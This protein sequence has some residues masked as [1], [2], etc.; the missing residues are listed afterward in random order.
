[1]KFR[2]LTVIIVLITAIFTVKIF[3]NFQK[4]WNRAE[5]FQDVIINAPLFMKHLL[6]P[7]KQ[8]GIDKWDLGD[9]A[10][11]QLKT[12]TDSRR[13]SFSV[14]AQESGG[15]KRHWLRTDGLSQFNA[16]P[17]EL[18]RLLSEAS[19]LPGTE[20]DGFFYVG[21]S[22][23]FPLYPAMFPP[24]PILLQDLGAETVQ[25]PI[26]KFKCRHYFVQ[27]RAPSGHL[28]PLLELWANTSVPPLGI[29]RARWRDETLDL[30]D[31]KAPL[32]IE[33]PDVLSE[34]FNQN[35]AQDHGCAQC[36]HEDIGGKDLKFL[37]KYL[38]SSTE[39]N[40]TQYLFHYYQTGL[41]LTSDPIRLQTISKPGQ[42]TSRELVQFTW[43][44]GSFWVKA[45]QRGQLTFSLDH[46]VSQ[47]KL[48][49]IPRKGALVLNLQKR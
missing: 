18:W 38:L 17:L 23:L 16:A 22:F 6:I 37:S 46:L 10:A 29:V 48:S 41:I 9:Y 28:E 8:L 40:L 42:I 45:N 32:P 3:I 47:G 39:L 19:L 5:I 44:K 25:T 26:G 36:H 30:V 34:T 1:M 20:A 7:P 21:K 11:Y 4:R 49:V 14:D 12:N 27:A 33:I 2:L 24:S 43:T 15:G 31:V 35:R 13:L